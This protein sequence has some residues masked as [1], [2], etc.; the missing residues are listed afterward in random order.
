MTSYRQRSNQWDSWP[1]PLIGISLEPGIIEGKAGRLRGIIYPA[2]VFLETLSERTY[3]QCE[4]HEYTI[5]IF[6]VHQ[7][8]SVYNWYIVLK[9]A[10]WLNILETAECDTILHCDVS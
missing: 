1:G 8:T 9:Y 5:M 2:Q 6:A 10:H 3:V 4:M 7:K